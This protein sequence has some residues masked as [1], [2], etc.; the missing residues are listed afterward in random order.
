MILPAKEIKKLLP[1][2]ARTLRKLENRIGPITPIIDKML[3]KKN[4][5]RILEIGFGF[6]PVLMKLRKLYGDRVELYG[7]NKKESHGNWEIMK[8]V[9]ISTK[10]FTKKEISKIKS[11]IL[12]FQDADNGLPFPSNYFD[13]VYSQAA[14]FYFN[15][16]AKFLE[17]LN[18]VLEK[19]G[20]AKISV[21]IERDEIPP[22]YSTSFEIW[23][24]GKKISFWKYIKKFPTLKENRY[25]RGPMLE[26][27]K[28]KKLNLKLK[29][30]YAL[31]L[32]NICS[33]WW[34]TK[35][36]YALE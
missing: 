1:H 21:S 34:G 13:F 2:R 3:E 11:P 26:M 27:K 31:N 7:I 6:G 12:H 33:R 15:E 28:A 18:M 19:D 17:E 22:E 4:K 10:I 36:I 29:L 23:Q 5:I 24:N 30:A 8:K 32:N 25:K 14:F 20:I 16:K 35:S 9:A